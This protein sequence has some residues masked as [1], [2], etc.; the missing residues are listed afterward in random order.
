MAR[1]IP[2]F[3]IFHSLPQIDIHIKSHIRHISPSNVNHRA[4][5]DELANDKLS[6]SHLGL[7]SACLTPAISPPPHSAPGR[8][9]E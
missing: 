3:T 8:M 9:W 2:P 1:S 5:N 7:L 4:G 6:Q